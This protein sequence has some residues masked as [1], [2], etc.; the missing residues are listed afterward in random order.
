[1]I[2]F[3]RGIR[4]KLLT[5][6][7]FSKYLIYAIGEIILVVIGILIALSFNNW[8][9]NR[10]KQNKGKEYVTEIYKDLKKDVLEINAIIEKLET[11]KIN[12]RAVLQI[13]ESKENY[14]ADSSLFVSN[15][16]M[17]SAVIDVRRQNRTWDELISSGQIAIINNDS[18]DY[19]LKTFYDYYDKQVYQ[20]SE[21]PAQSREKNRTAISRCADLSSIDRYWNKEG[22]KGF[23]K[24]WFRCI[25][26]DPEIKKDIAVIYQSTYWQI[27]HFTRVKEEGQSII[28]YMDNRI[29][30][31]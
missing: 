27:F 14:I 21:T 22:D 9:E 3:F 26:N 6:N 1:M 24:S 16:L 23:N 8:N 20:F 7:K 4:Q 13:L 29:M 28:D 10:K 30:L 12:S 17:T 18:L 5:E 2:K 15:T 11:N 31:D 19:L 25:I